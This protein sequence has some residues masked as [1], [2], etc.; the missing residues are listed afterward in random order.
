MIIREADCR[1]QLVACQFCIIQCWHGH[2]SRQVCR[3]MVYNAVEAHVV[4]E[5]SVVIMSCTNT[6]ANEFGE[7]R[8][9]A[10]QP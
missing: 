6:A 5:H 3:T 9:R 8:C 1:G 2:K 4:L 10:F 7:L